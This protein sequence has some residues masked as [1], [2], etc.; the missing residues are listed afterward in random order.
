MSK[1]YFQKWAVVAFFDEKEEGFEFH[2][3]DVPLHATL[4]GVFAFAGNSKA[5]NEVIETQIS[6]LVAFDV[7][8]KEMAQW[9]GCE[10]DGY[11]K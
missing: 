5:I 6:D 8:G 3:L 9:G 4:V 11:R 1:K 2:R 7:W 10:G